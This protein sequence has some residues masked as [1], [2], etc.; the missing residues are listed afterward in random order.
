MAKILP[1]YEGPTVS[2]S[3]RMPEGLKAELLQVSKATG[4]PVSDVTIFFLR[5]AVE[6]WKAEEAEK[7]SR[8]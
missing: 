1:K 3:I 7:K 4:H 5:W 2:T 8:R 6:E